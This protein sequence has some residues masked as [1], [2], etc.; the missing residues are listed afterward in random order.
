MNNNKPT[1][2]AFA[3]PNGSGKSTITA[4]IAPVG[5]YINAD[6][7]QRVR[8][9]DPMEAAK[10]AERT[11]EYYLSRNGDFTFETVMSTERNVLLLERARAMGYDVEC[12]YVTTCNPDINVQR[13][14]VRMAAGGNAV[15]EEKIVPRYWRA[16]QFI[17][18]LCNACSRLLIFDNSD[19]RLQG[20]E[21]TLIVEAYN[22]SAV[23]HPT[24]HW[25]EAQLNDLVTGKFEPR[26]LTL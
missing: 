3:G 4:A 21:P 13:V 10:I 8:G 26:S 19:D 14:L 20:G 15:P 23:I 7:I 1:V 6:E 12:I 17:P 18:R 2:L 11:R 22:G 5:V 9:C 16:M 24:K 25:N